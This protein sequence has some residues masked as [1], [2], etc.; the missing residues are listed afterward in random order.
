MDE[1]IAGEGREK[2]WSLYW[3]KVYLAE[4]G[5]PRAWPIRKSGRPPRG[6]P[7]NAFGLSNRS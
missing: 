5:A 7:G 3:Y 4:G 6:E 1:V 2:G